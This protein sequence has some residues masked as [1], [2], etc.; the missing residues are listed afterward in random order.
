M[1]T[2]TIKEENIV[3][4]GQDF[5]LSDF[6]QMYPPPQIVKVEEGYMDSEEE[7]RTL[8][9]SQVLTLHVIKNFKT[10]PAF[11]KHGEKISLPVN[12]TARLEILCNPISY[13]TVEELAKDF[14]RYVASVEKHPWLKVEENDVLELKDVAKSF[15]SRVLVCRNVTRGSKCELPLDYKAHFKS[16]GDCPVIHPT[17]NDIVTHCKLP[18]QAKY[19]DDELKVIHEGCNANLPFGMNVL[20]AIKLQSVAVNKILLITAWEDDKVVPLPLDLDIRVVAAVGALRNDHNY[21]KLCKIAHNKT[22]VE[23]LELM[24]IKEGSYRVLLA[25]RNSEILA[26]KDD[27]DD[28]VDT[29]SVVAPQV[30]SRN[31]KPNQ[32]SQNTSLENDNI[33]RSGES[34]DRRRFGRSVS[35]NLPSSRPNNPEEVFDDS[36]RSY[37][38]T[39][40]SVSSFSPM[41]KVFHDIKNKAA[42]AKKGILTNFNKIKRS[43]ANYED[44]DHEMAPESSH[45]HPGQA[46][47]SHAIASQDTDWHAISSH[48]AIDH[49]TKS[50]AIG[51][52][53]ITDHATT[54]NVTNNP[55]AVLHTNTIPEPTGGHAISSH[56]PDPTY[57]EVKALPRN[58]QA[59]KF[60]ETFF[61]R[62]LGRRYVPDCKIRNPDNIM[63]WTIEEVTEC[64]RYCRLD[65]YIDVFLKE[66][67]DGCLLADLDEE[68]L[69]SLGV[70]DKLHLTKMMKI[71]Q[72][73]WLP[74]Y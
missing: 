47:R 45:V 48:E 42:K 18:I 57:K 51:G 63:T 31:L 37:V 2:T 60:N 1:S 41:K 61:R 27:N 17:M 74:K 12:S 7:E 14:P 10:V 59:D 29:Y 22:K 65:Q 40:S 43:S 55:T 19:I 50:H 4:S 38:D 24:F 28:E 67:I 33:K 52:H 53:E 73:G 39:E 30:P 56:V 32:R 6:V 16:L 21:A 3:W 13:E 36:V 58:I 49:A 64:L 44:Y 71:I 11:D 23:D 25:Q 66:M 9:A 20:G 35:L 5:K 68:A 26:Q 69:R 54:S 8:S 34:R 62:S 70:N 15:R 46:P 72:D